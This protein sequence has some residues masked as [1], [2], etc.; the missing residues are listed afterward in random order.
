MTRKEL[1]LLAWQFVKDNKMNK[2]DAM[3]VAWDNKNLV[4]NMRIGVVEFKFRKL[5]G[6]ERLAHG[7]L[8]DDMLPETKGTGKQ[9]HKSVQVYY[10]TDAREW[11]C[12]KKGSLIKMK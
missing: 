6:S 10:D 9:P 3:V 7:T 1:M 8:R 5:D 2:S 11:R 12:F 4:D